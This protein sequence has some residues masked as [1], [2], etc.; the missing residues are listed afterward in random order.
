MDFKEQLKSSVDIVKVIGEYVRLRKS[1]VSR[2]TGLCPFHSEKTPS[3]SV[4]AGHQFYKCFGCGASGRV[5]KSEMEF[6]RVVF[7]WAIKRLAERS[8]IP[9]PKR[10]E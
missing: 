3:F 7:P 10:A 2:Y 9:M 5:L 4:Q 8:G 6:E 1:G